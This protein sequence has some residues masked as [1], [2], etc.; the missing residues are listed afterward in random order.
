MK[1]FSILWILTLVS[2]TA[3]AISCTSDQEETLSRLS[4]AQWVVLYN[5]YD[6]GAPYDLGHTMMAIAFHESKAGVYRA[7]LQTNDSGVMQNNLAT[8][9]ARRG[10]SGYYATMELVSRLVRDDVL[11]MQLALEELLYWRDSRK[12][13]WKDMISAYNSGNNYA[14]N[15]AYLTK[16]V[17]V[18]Q[19]FMQCVQL[20]LLEQEDYD[21]Y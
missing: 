11:S 4:P 7:N 19:M 3:P 8:A 20:V 14:Y 18:T 15:K 16:L 21:E 10:I 13:S 9:K 12:L 2:C 6:V 17:P 5:A 1:L